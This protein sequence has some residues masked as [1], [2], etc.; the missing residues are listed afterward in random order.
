M[1]SRMKHG[2][3]FLVVCLMSGGTVFSQTLQLGNPKLFVKLDSMCRTPDAI[4]I[5]GAGNIYLSVTNATTFDQFGARI[6]K[7]SPGG[8]C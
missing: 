8:R 3:F 1:I 4:A 7:L 2:L 5:D 6:I